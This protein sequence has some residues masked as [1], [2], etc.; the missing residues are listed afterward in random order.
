M[1][2]IAAILVAVV[3]SAAVILAR[4]Q[5]WGGETTA[6]SAARASAWVALALLWA[7]V[8]TGIGVSLKYHPGISGQV[9]TL[10]LHRVTGSLALSF[11]V[12]HAVALV[13]DPYIRFAPWD[14]AVPF[15]APYRPLATGLGVIAAWL[16]SAV[17]LSTWGA[18]WLPRRAWHLIHRASYAALAL[19]LVHGIAA[20][21]DTE[22]WPTHVAY[23]A[24]A[25]SVLGAAFLRFLARDWV[26]AHRAGRRSAPGTPG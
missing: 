4:Q 16:V 8:F 11:T 23:T 13:A 9:P 10:E 2:R 7:A 21:T 15:V 17:V 18:G 6:W 24:I 12:V 22:H 20:G 19:G 5:G 3:A 14:A 26:A 1:S 25:A